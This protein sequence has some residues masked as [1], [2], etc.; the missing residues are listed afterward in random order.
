[1]SKL[2]KENSTSFLKNIMFLM[3]SQVV[4]KLLGLVYRVAIV[5]A[6]GFG[7]TGNGYYATGYQVYMV[8][9]A[10]SCM[11]IGN[12]VSKLVSERAAKG[13]F[14]GAHRV[15]RLMLGMFAGFGFFL[16]LVLFFGADFISTVLLK[17]SGVK[18]TLMVLAPALTIVSVSAVLR[19]YFSGLGSMKALGSSQVIEQIFNCILSIA[20]V[21]MCIGYDS[22]VMA[23]AGN[24][25]TT[26]ACAIA[27][28]Y[29]I[30]YYRK[31]RP[32]IKEQCAKQE[33]PQESISRRRLVKIIIAL[34][35]PIA[36][37]SLITTI[38]S[39][40]DIFTV[41]HGIQNALAQQFGYSADVLEEAAMSLY[42]TMQKA[43]VITHLPLAISGT[44]CAAIVPAISSHL[45]KGEM[46]GVN[47]KISSASLV[48]SLLIF[49][50]MGGLM[51]LAGPILQMLYP[52]APE[53]SLMLILLCTTLPFSSLTYVLN[54]ILYGA[55][56]QFVPAV[57]IGIGSAIKL[58]L[59]LI[60]VN[61]PAL[62]IYGAIIGT[63][64][65]QVF[66]FAVE[67]V[68][69]YRVVD[70]KMNYVKTFVKPFV[71]AAAMSVTVF[72]AYK[73]FDSFA[74][75]TLSTIMSICVGV[76]VY[77]VFILVFKTFN[78]A[79]L[80]GL[81]MGNKIGALL[82]RFHLLGN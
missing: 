82:K 46:A 21:Y 38:N 80:E 28:I 16:T 34:A 45:A 8:L 36:I 12:V 48:S 4:V 18:Y 2:K 22:A 79:D 30:V 5:D 81:P 65:Y 25:S 73:L 68:F 7:N 44:L 74:G 66:V 58:V 24:I 23:A 37:S 72:F 17:A 26:V 71:A 62:N 39:I 53:G 64:V 57:S 13:D 41:S 14:K 27:L 9:L 3:F 55:G 59:N 15:F 70:I 51:V 54:G 47:S 77:A 50:C 29:L 35:F 43:E 20:F 33:V 76:V 75:N 60:L 40:I 56:K 6:E 1:M 31:R 67:T 32:D 61:I 42:G 63:I 78:E 49:P 10:I 19:G 52:S 11:G 69:V